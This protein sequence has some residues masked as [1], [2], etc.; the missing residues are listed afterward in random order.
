MGKLETFLSI[1]IFGLIF[2]FIIVIIVGYGMVDD[3]PLLDV[4]VLPNTGFLSSCVT[5]ICPE[6]L[7]CDISS[8]TCKLP[9]NSECSNNEQCVF[10]TFC[11]GICVSVTDAT[12]GFGDFC[13]CADFNV[14][15]IGATGSVNICKGGSGAPCT[16]NADCNFKLCESNGTCS[17]SV[18]LPNGFMCKHGSN[19]ESLNCSN[20][21]CQPP[22]SSIS[23]E[24]PG[25]A[26]ATCYDNNPNVTY[27]CT[28]NPGYFQICNC[29]EPLTSGI[30]VVQNLNFNETCSFSSQF[31]CVAGLSCLSTTT[32]E[33][34]EGTEQCGC[35]FPYQN[36]TEVAMFEDCISGTNRILD[37]CFNGI[38][39]GCF[40][41]TM[42]VT[43]AFCRGGSVLNY[44]SYTSSVT[45]R[46]SGASDLAISGYSGPTA[47]EDASVP[48]KLFFYNE[49]VYLVD[50]KIGFYSWISETWSLILY[51]QDDKGTLIDACGSRLRQT[52]YPI[53]PG[54]YTINIVLYLDQSENSVLYYIEGANANFTE[55][56]V[57]NYAMYPPGSTTGIQTVG[58]IPIN[59]I[60]FVE[61]T[62]SSYSSFYI[63][64]LASGSNIYIETSTQGTYSLLVSDNIGNPRFYYGDGSLS[65]NV[66]YINSNN[67]IVF[68]GDYASLGQFPFDPFGGD[69]TYEVFDFNVYGD[70]SSNNAIIALIEIFDGQ[71]ES[72]GTATVLYYTGGPQMFS[73]PKTYQ[74][75]KTLITNA[76]YYIYS[77]SS[78]VG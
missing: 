68:L 17:S 11:S 62:R 2:L 4:S 25:I 52:T 33:T 57:N 45:L 8:L 43:D 42:C 61:V 24:E 55:N 44:F 15:V 71:G 75:Q 64:L 27:N 10:G 73:P 41:D 1:I 36:P 56:E 19:C 67:E 49:I 21:V 3:V 74:G 37:Q 28:A 30:C 69:A 70:S 76:A 26:C 58:G 47:T 12:G 77:A 66:A 60:D 40:N 54:W 48:H 13:P 16:T 5:E 39:V 65:S 38:N 35:Y 22:G 53:N 29:V 20:F 50:S 32:G 34:C 14:C 31:F 7:E 18:G 51:Q 6:D 78:C 9:L 63:V 23:Q 72:L 59:N 46:Y